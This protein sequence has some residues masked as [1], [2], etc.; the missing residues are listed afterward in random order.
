MAGE[1]SAS[2]EGVRS[3]F[4]G[5]S[6]SWIDE[7]LLGK[8]LAGAF[9]D[10]GLD[11]ARAW[12]TVAVIKLLTSHQLWASV[13]GPTAA[14]TARVPGGEYDVPAPNMGYRVPDARLRAHAVLEAL[15][16]DDEVQQYLHV[17]RYQ[18][19]LWFNKE[20][21]VQLL[22]WLL[23]VETVQAVA[24]WP[25]RQALAEVLSADEVLQELRQAEEQSGYQVEEL[26]RLLN[27]PPRQQR[28]TQ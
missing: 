27:V 6:R 23:L 22:R 7:W 18:D 21:F 8:V 16:K 17:N 26:V 9:Q 2:Q 11:E 1:A 12:H 28:G 13:P 5:Q 14:E 25:A 10:M 15:L 3:L 24:A 19:V 20:A 4:V